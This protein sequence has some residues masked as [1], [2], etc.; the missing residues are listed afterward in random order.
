MPSSTTRGGFRLFV[1]LIASLLMGNA[2]A[3]ST[4]L[5]VPTTSAQ[6]TS[7]FTSTSMTS[8]PS[9]T[10]IPPIATEDPCGLL[11]GKPFSL[12]PEVYA[13]YNVFEASYDFK[14]DHVATLKQFLDIYPFTDLY[15]NTPPRQFSYTYFLGHDAPPT[16]TYV[17]T[18]QTAALTSPSPSLGWLPPFTALTTPTV[19]P[20]TPTTAPSRHPTDDNRIPPSATSFSFTPPPNSHRP[21]TPADLLPSVPIAASLAN[22]LTLGPLGSTLRVS[23][24][25]P[26]VSDNSTAFYMLE[27]G[28]TGVV[29]FTE[30]VPK[31]V[32][33]I[34]G[35]LQSLEKRGAKRLIIDVSGNGGGYFCISTAIAEYLF[36]KTGMIVDQIRFTPST[37]ALLNIDFYGFQGATPSPSTTTPPSSPPPTPKTVV[38]V[39]N[40]SLA[41]FDSAKAV[42]KPTFSAPCSRLQNG[43]NPK[44]LRLSVTVDVGVLVLAW[45]Y[46]WRGFW[47]DFHT[48]FFEGGVVA[49]FMDVAGIPED[50]RGNLTV[51]ERRVVPG[52]FS[53]VIYGQI[54]FTQGYSM[55]GWKEGME[56]WYPA[57][58]VRQDADGHVVVERGFEVRE[59]W[60]EVARR[61]K[62]GEGSM[63]W[64]V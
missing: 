39:P 15:I 5:T 23:I 28:E 57:E 32:A 53:S 29:S 55:E 50:V 8:Q 7:T 49:G 9:S 45:L 17:I 16:R 60:R 10:T 2:R 61:M 12:L 13:C 64:V 4:T 51:E 62:E 1:L 33:T 21:I 3:Q 54:P 18:P 30:V 52:N 37:R 34:V 26:L 43:W 6:A 41:S 58:F 11:I 36:P 38:A 46:L 14:K 25:S 27:D 56:K 24:D 19:T 20:I 59:V 40:P 31:W 42:K 63:G 47:L 22:T 48:D 44:M 35:G